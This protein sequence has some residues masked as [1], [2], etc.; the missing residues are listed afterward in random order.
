MNIC[1]THF[2]ATCFVLAMLATQA[3]AQ[4][5]AEYVAHLTAAK[6]AARFEAA[7]RTC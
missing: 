3:Q 6:N 2:A 7:D 1:R 4:L 5:P